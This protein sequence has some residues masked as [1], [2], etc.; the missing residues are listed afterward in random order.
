MTN[1]ALNPH[2]EKS[3]NADSGRVI[4]ELREHLEAAVHL[5][6][7]LDMAIQMPLL[8]LLDELSFVEAI[9]RAEAS[10]NDSPGPPCG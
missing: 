2:Y 8:D 5:A 10:P 7:T 3:P 4:A 1:P 6:Y 9:R